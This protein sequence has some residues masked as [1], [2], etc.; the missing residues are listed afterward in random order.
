MLLRNVCKLIGLISAILTCITLF[1]FLHLFTV[2][3]PT[4]NGRICN[5]KGT[6]DILT[7]MC[8]CDPQWSGT[9]C[10]FTACPGFNQ[11]TATVCY[12]RGV[13]A[14]LMTS[15]EIPNACL[16]GYDTSACAYH[17]KNVD[18]GLLTCVCRSPYSGDSCELN[19]CPLDITGTICSGNGNKSVG[20]LTNN[21][22]NVETGCQ[23][24]S[25]FGFSQ[26]KKTLSAS[27]I[28]GLKNLDFFRKGLCAS[29]QT[30]STGALRFVQ[31]QYVCYCDEMHFGEVCEFGTCP[32]FLDKTC[33]GHGHPRYGYG[34]Q[35][36]V[37]LPAI[38]T[39]PELCDPVCAAGYYTWNQTCTSKIG[40][41]A[42]C[43]PDK[44]YRCTNGDCVSAAIPSCTL[45][46]EYGYHSEPNL[47]K[48]KCK[49]LLNPGDVTNEVVFSRYQL[50]IKE[51]GGSAY[52]LDTDQLTLVETLTFSDR[53]VY[54]HLEITDATFFPFQ[55]FYNDKEVA[56]VSST[57]L[58][59]G[60]IADENRAEWELNA[61]KHAF[62]AEVEIVSTSIVH[63]LTTN[64]SLENT[65]V[66]IGTQAV[67]ELQSV[68]FSFTNSSNLYLAVVYSKQ[69]YISNVGV[70]V[71]YLTCLNDI[72]KCVWTGTNLTNANGQRLCQNGPTDFTLRR[73]ECTPWQDLEPVQVVYRGRSRVSFSTEVIGT[74]KVE[75]IQS[76]N[77]VNEHKLE[78]K[79]SAGF[80]VNP[81][82]N[83]SSTVFLKRDELKV[84]CICATVDQ[85]K[86]NKT[87][88]DIYWLQTR[89]DPPS[90]IGDH[91]VFKYIL[92]GDIVTI[93]GTLVS[94]TEFTAA[95]VIPLPTLFQ[96]AVFITPLEF[97]DGQEVCDFSSVRSG[98]A[99]PCAS[100]SLLVL[101]DNVDKCNC[102]ISL[103]YKSPC[104]CISEFG[105]V[106]NRSLHVNTSGIVC[107][108][109]P[110]HLLEGEVLSGANNVY[111]SAQFPWSII[112]SNVS[113]EVFINNTWM[114]QV[115]EGLDGEFR[116]VEYIGGYNL[117]RI[118][119][120]SS[121]KWITF[122]FPILPTVR[123]ASSN[124]ELLPNLEWNSGTFWESE[125]T[126]PWIVYDWV[127]EP[128]YIRG[129]VIEFETLGIWI[130]DSLT[131]DASA[132]IYID[133]G[134]G[135]VLL[136]IIT[137]TV[138]EGS[139]LWE[140]P[141]NT[142]VFKVKLKSMYKMR[143]RQFQVFT[144]QD[145]DVKIIDNGPQLPSWT[146]ED[147][148]TEGE[149]IC[150]DSC[151][152]NG[153]DVSK[154]GYCNDF[155]YY[156]LNN[157]QVPEQ[158]VT[159]TILL[160]ENL[161]DATITSNSTIKEWRFIWN[162]SI[163]SNNS[164]LVPGELW[165]YVTGDENLVV[166]NFTSATLFECTM[167]N[168]PALC[169]FRTV[170]PYWPADI[171]AGSC[172]SGFDC[173]DCGSNKRTGKIAVGAQCFKRDPSFT[174]TQYSIIELIQGLGATVIEQVNYTHSTSK[175]YI[176]CPWPTRCSDGTCQRYCPEPRYNCRGNG[177]IRTS[178]VDRQYKCVCDRGYGGLDCSLHECQEG[179]PYTGLI[180]PHAWCS[181]NGFGPL[182]IKPPFSLVQTAKRGYSTAE[183]LVLNRRGRIKTSAL[184]VRN[185]YIQSDHAPFGIAILRYY[186]EGARTVYTTCPF[187][188]RDRMGIARTL[189]E[190]VVS[191]SLV[192]PYEVTEWRTFYDPDGNPYQ[193][194]WSSETQYD[195]FPFRCQPSGECVAKSTDCIK[196]D[197]AC[198]SRGSAMVDGTC[199]CSAGW[200]T[201]FIT[202]K[203][204][205][206]AVTPYNADNP[207]IWGYV[208]ELPLEMALKIYTMQQCAARNCSE[209]NCG[210]PR[211]CFPG[212][213]EL[214]F[215]DK[216]HT[217]TVAGPYQGKCSIDE[218]ACVNGQNISNPIVCSGKGLLQRRDYRSEYY[219][220]CGDFPDGATDT[221]QL[222]PNGFGGLACEHY[223]CQEN[224][225]LYYSK[226]DPFT[227][228]A[229][230]NQEG[231]TLPG[232]WMGGC[233]APAGPSFDP[234]DS[235]S[236]SFQQWQSCCPNGFETCTN[237]I[238]KIR[239]TGGLNT[240][241]SYCL[242]IQDCIGDGRTPD[243]YVC[244]GHGI[245][246]SN[247]E[248]KCEQTDTYGYTYNPKYYSY[249]GCFQK[250]QC[251]LSRE[252]GKMCNKAD[253]CSESDISR[254]IA[255][256]RLDYME[257]QLP[258]IASLE[259]IMMSNKSLALR[260][261]PELQQRNKI[262][263]Q[264]YYELGL[265][266]LDSIRGLASDVCIY[267]ND[268]AN[269][270][271]IITHASLLT[272]V[273][274]NY[275]YLQDS[276]IYLNCT[277]ERSVSTSPIV[278]TF[279]G[280]T[281]VKL[282]RY[283]QYGTGSIQITF[284][285]PD[286]NLTESIPGR[287]TPG[288]AW[289]EIVFEA[290][291]EDFNYQLQVPFLYMNKCPFSENDSTCKEWMKSY[292]ENNENGVYRQIPQNSI[293]R[294]CS[295][296]SKCCKKVQIGIP[297][298][299]TFQIVFTDAYISEIQV[300]G[301][302]VSTVPIIPGG[303]N[304]EIISKIGN[305]TCQDEYFF[306]S[307]FGVRGS[308]F[309]VDT[310]TSINYTQATLLCEDRAGVIYSSNAGPSIERAFPAGD[311]CKDKLPCMTSGREISTPVNP[312]IEYFLSTC[313]YHGCFHALDTWYYAI[314]TTDSDGAL[315]KSP[316]V[317]GQLTGEQW[318]RSWLE[319]KLYAIQSGLSTH[320]GYHVNYEGLFSDPERS[321]SYVKF[322]GCIR[323]PEPGEDV[324][325]CKILTDACVQ[326]ARST[327][328]GRL[329]TEY[330]N[331][332]QKVFVTYDTEFS[333]LCMVDSSQPIINT[334]PSP[335]SF[336]TSNL[337][338][339]ITKLQSSF[340][341]GTGRSSTN[342]PE[343]LF[344]W[345]ND[346]PVCKIIFFYE[347]YCNTPYLFN[348]VTACTGFGV[349]TCNGV[350]RRA[351]FHEIIITSSNYEQFF[352]GPIDLQGRSFDKCY[353]GEC[354]G[355]G[356]NIMAHGNTR[357]IVIQGPCRLSL[358][359]TTAAF[360]YIGDE[361]YGGFSD[362]SASIPNDLRAN[363]NY[364]TRGPL[365]SVLYY[366]MR[367]NDFF[368][369]GRFNTRTKQMDNSIKIP[370]G[371]Y[372]DLLDDH[373]LY[374]I[375]PNDGFYSMSIR[376][377]F[378]SDLI[379]HT[380]HSEQRST[381]AAGSDE[382]TMG[383]FDHPYMCTS[384][385]IERVGQ[386]RYMDRYRVNPTV[387]ISKENP[388]LV[389][390]SLLVPTNLIIPTSNYKYCSVQFPGFKK[391]TECF[392]DRE[393]GNW[394]W[395]D[396]FYSTNFA[397]EI[398]GMAQYTYAGRK[399]PTQIH[400]HWTKG[401]IPRTSILTQLETTERRAYTR[402]VSVLKIADYLEK[403][404]LDRCVVVNKTL[405]TYSVPNQR[406]EATTTG[407]TYKYEFLP[408]ICS[409]ITRPIICQRD[410]YPYTALT[411]YMC[412]VCGT[413]S[414]TNALEPY[415]TPADK[416]PLANPDNFP[417]E[418]AVKDA[419]V[420][421]ELDVLIESEENDISYDWIMHY[422]LVNN[423]ESLVIAFP[424]VR[425]WLVEGYSSRPVFNSRG[426]EEDVDAW[427]DFRFQS[428][429][430]YTCP[431]IKNPDTGI[432][433]LRCATNL[434]TCAYDSTL[435][436]PNMLFGDVP[437]I[438]TTGIT[439]DISDPRCGY[440][441]RPQDITSTDYTGFA[442]N[443]NCVI[444]QTHADFLV[445]QLLEYNLSFEN[446]GKRQ[447]ILPSSANETNLFTQVV[448]NSDCTVYIDVTTY[449]TN[450]QTPPRSFQNI[451]SATVG[452]GVQTQ[453]IREN[454]SRSPN[455][456]Q[457][458]WRIDCV[459]IDC[460]V[461]L[462]PIVITTN[463]T[464]EQ[465][466]TP[467]YINPWKELPTAVDSAA[468]DHTCDFDN[469]GSCV[470]DP[471]YPDGGPT[472]DWP[473][474][475][476]TFGKQIC[477]GYG[478][479][480]GVSYPDKYEVNSLGVYFDK[481]QYQCK[482]ANPG[483][484]FH[485]R[486]LQIIRDPFSVIRY[487]D[488][489]GLNS[490]YLV[491]VPDD[492]SS[493]V[494]H[495]G[496]TQTVCASE[497]SIL[498]SFISGDELAGFLS[499]QDLRIGIHLDLT[500]SLDNKFKWNVRNMDIAPVNGTLIDIDSLPASITNVNNLLYG[501]AG[502]GLLTD[503]Y[504]NATVA[505][506]TSFTFVPPDVDRNY[507]IQIV[508]DNSA[509]VTSDPLVACNPDVEAGWHI[510]QGPLID[511]K[512]VTTT[513]KEARM[514]YA[515]QT[516]RFFP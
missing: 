7:N 264:S 279:T 502:G 16:D 256:P 511:I 104:T 17:L 192:Y 310:F 156:T 317:T 198:N 488:V 55:I 470:C 175:L 117:Y 88:Q 371:C 96:S 126:L 211:G 504:T 445:I 360:S 260:L 468:P 290:I 415:V 82:V 333:R 357:S 113:V 318:Y 124:S 283:Y 498:P 230:E 336:T 157:S 139:S 54:Y 152:V 77:T 291:Y 515:E 238:C 46:P 379:K 403:F 365:F 107:N 459:D 259:G 15:S 506:Y 231:V 303:F 343:T 74:L 87:D 484:S 223:L 2:N 71:D 344:Y 405:V 221:S 189:E 486:L 352:N 309:F 207:L 426:V 133:T 374:D 345:T 404:E 453:L 262:V 84:P 162:A 401:V 219:C 8:I 112:G 241:K 67:I 129:L 358:S 202:D 184:D 296:T 43:P 329:Y 63:I 250:Q 281:N 97:Q 185:E 136:D 34:F 396:R 402:L 422:I 294:G 335:S 234:S 429:F 218:V 171:Y 271:T 375:Y 240:E 145:C 51:C 408:S 432:S 356:F 423:P 161:T 321:S 341:A 494:S 320:P 20:L 476:T 103:E 226:F 510:C 12:G 280:V 322:P 407:T 99:Y 362:F 441:L 150:Q 243:I 9:S 48:G 487:D 130:D 390:G 349:E 134:S 70:L 269:Y 153:M 138:S 308:L 105:I 6:V 186:L 483:L 282:L 508:S 420:N 324:S 323:K 199:E 464:L 444:L 355:L 501:Y 170:A 64:L 92:Y 394:R 451:I 144:N 249:K 224:L 479:F 233:N 49:A 131:L 393:Y 263:Y 147:F 491:D 109:I 253:T 278:V 27:R 95:P 342:D 23:C 439:P 247:G 435:S 351:A 268:T 225:K 246:L 31:N 128:R 440:A 378:D 467:V 354:E 14:P 50:L 466:A 384:H 166:W 419:I 81:I 276:E 32:K 40:I 326:N 376:P 22:G 428:W 209:V 480:G 127:S 179:D 430:P 427:V 245:A 188:V 239:G 288:C 496:T 135:W 214:G 125:D 65:Y 270:G 413:L 91:G 114:V 284:V 392:P 386:V 244:N 142:W 108:F 255:F 297:P 258:V 83:G 19:G 461:I 493:P 293:L 252:S 485:T 438:I 62:F 314:S 446:T 382:F 490:W 489:F 267:P 180:D 190:C 13:C 123:S 363:F 514:Y 409:R 90:I 377:L 56:F 416:F 367:D 353:P 53:L 364:R 499:S 383:Y 196:A 204:T 61:F 372:A 340:I 454:F 436:I 216:Q 201:W 187:L 414:R 398:E 140:I 500:I 143:I 274:F 503:G 98:T 155:L 235:T 458:R 37:S 307:L 481:E 369:N 455:H 176:D 325:K 158:V 412:D 289:Q 168:L 473:A 203:E 417:F 421:G 327:L 328:S 299:Q 497:S 120:S 118:N 265:R 42:S 30:T 106:E 72:L 66:R 505:G 200:Q 159:D 206:R 448:C 477:G 346:V 348:V 115:V 111:E 285:N 21:T 85:D 220:A 52:N 205:S 425:K 456:T 337:I 228:K 58:Y 275:P 516:T 160:F 39:T 25:W 165:W 347:R 306:T 350:S 475:I 232:R 33:A 261:I 474:S 212:T 370:N 222:T 330:F 301:N 272:N 507:K 242:P 319:N 38:Q 437:K 167:F 172:Q 80:Y 178:L 368:E 463:T 35:E 164:E 45:T 449:E 132:E 373:S 387:L 471:A 302:V 69:V 305:T 75:S 173:S 424:Q 1:P 339:R 174:P 5:G 47:I 183:I 266:V 295:A 385:Q 410:Y 388:I 213:P 338:S 406:F 151:T 116:L 146:F 457:L 469:G 465:C 177:C 163:V 3:Y 215:T 313:S 191:R 28:R 300:Y 195:D 331:T 154:D 482:C 86:G 181:S 210:I 512:I 4:Y 292:C 169:T 492:I 236:G 101:E 79:N 89:I 26:L 119:G 141:V 94:A 41:A 100:V 18:P 137:D 122:G 149:C 443:P 509:T 194:I 57:G 237:V 10:E 495:A 251:Q 24:T 287:L 462:Y 121:I 472:C 433:R 452:A 148:T 513:A 93:R 229:Y 197:P 11:E 450:Y 110:A 76:R 277:N 380:L 59:E 304:K 400:V 60:L 312:T 399:T 442:V 68:E 381:N 366:W 332:I 447:F 102:T 248:C 395:I 227:G 391:C 257:Q 44:I 316:R 254:W 434:Q 315:W 411:G 36:N 478:A 334:W 193:I 431:R 311:L 361:S 78:F 217:C 418:H 286:T 298:I 460:V 359:T 397:N 73:T 182:K 389:Q 208:Q 273:Q 29:L